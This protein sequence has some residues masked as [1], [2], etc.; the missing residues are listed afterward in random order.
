M[1]RVSILLVFPIACLTALG[2]T[3]AAQNAAPPAGAALP[4]LNLGLEHLDIIVPRFAR[5]KG[6]AL[7]GLSAVARSAEVDV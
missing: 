2:I 6:P 1:R 7:S 3:A 5:A 4:L